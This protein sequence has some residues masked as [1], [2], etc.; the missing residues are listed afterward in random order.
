MSHPTAHRVS[1]LLRHTTHTSSTNN[2]LLWPRRANN[3]VGQSIIFVHTRATAKS[4][5]AR[6]R[7][8]GH[9]VSVLHA[10]I[11]GI[12]SQEV[13][14]RNAAVAALQGE[15][16]SLKAKIQRK[17]SILPELMRA[18]ALTLEG[19]PLG[20]GLFFSFMNWIDNF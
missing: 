7:Q 19:E 17:A 12:V 11:S 14:A 2:L 3:A 20:D 4:L 10:T 6:M 15:I 16:D 8:D 13:A 5:T 1:I 18:A 9:A